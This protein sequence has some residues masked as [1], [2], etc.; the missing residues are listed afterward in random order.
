MREVVCEADTGPV[1]GAEFAAV[2]ARA[3]GRDEEAF[4]RLFRDVQPALLRYL[5][6]T[7]PQAAEEVA[8]QTW[9]D[10]VAGLAGFHGG[11]KAVRAGRFTTPP[12]PAAAAPPAR[13][14]R[15]P[16]PPAARGAGGRLTAPPPPGG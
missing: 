3:Q 11:G 12:H 7:A 4:T 6:V 13:G 8:A 2:L 5:R 14:R 15:P 9:P 16:P 1:I 10:V